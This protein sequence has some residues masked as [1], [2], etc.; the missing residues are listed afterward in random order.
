MDA[1]KDFTYDPAAFKGFP[2][3][4]KELHNNGQKLV[5]IVVWA[6]LLYPHIRSLLFFVIE[7]PSPYLIPNFQSPFSASGLKL[8]SSLYFSPS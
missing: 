2:E 4:V 7:A 6:V 5:I 8:G 1:R 3:F